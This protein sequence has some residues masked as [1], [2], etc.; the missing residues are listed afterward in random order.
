MMLDENLPKPVSPVSLQA[1]TPERA[2]RDSTPVGVKAQNLMMQY[3]DYT[4][5][6]PQG[7]VVSPTNPIDG[8]HYLDCPK[9]WERI[10]SHPR[11][12]EVDIEELCAELNARLKIVATPCLLSPLFYISLLVLFSIGRLTCR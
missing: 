1:S 11:F 7:F 2:H 9:V 10:V 4:H 3:H 5:H 8:H 6:N 12:D